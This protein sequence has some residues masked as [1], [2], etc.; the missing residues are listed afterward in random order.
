MD[1]KGR[2]DFE[3]YPDRAV[4][5]PSLSAEDG[6]T[7]SAEDSSDLDWDVFLGSSPESDSS[8]LELT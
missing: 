7:T 3:R 1:N 5:S 4:D 6:D 2:S 8:A